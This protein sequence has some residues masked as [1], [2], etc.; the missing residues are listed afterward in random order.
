MARRLE[1]NH[2][3]VA[4]DGLVWRP[5]VSSYTTRLMLASRARWRIGSAGRRHDFVYNVP[6]SPPPTRWAEHHVHHLARLALPFGLEVSDG[7]WRPEIALTSAESMAAEW[8]WDAVAIGTTYESNYEG[9]VYTMRREAGGVWGP[10][11][12]LVVLD[13]IASFAPRFHHRNCSQ[14]WRQ[15][16]RLESLHGQ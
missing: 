5:S 9:A 2:Y 3:D 13:P 7:D 15:V 6:V 10:L 1:Q 8:R 16:V 4:I 14:V 12:R 11:R